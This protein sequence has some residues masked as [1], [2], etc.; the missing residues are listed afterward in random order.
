LR[1]LTCNVRSNVALLPVYRSLLP[2]LTASSRS[3]PSDP[4]Q[5]RNHRRVIDEYETHTEG[6]PRVKKVMIK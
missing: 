5:S 3:L 2:D 6:R 1:G 4:R